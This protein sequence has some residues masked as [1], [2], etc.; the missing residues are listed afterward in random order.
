VA[1]WAK[2]YFNVSICCFFN[3]VGHNLSDASR[4]VLIPQIGLSEDL[5]L[6]DSSKLQKGSQKI[7]RKAF[8]GNTGRPCWSLCPQGTTITYPAVRQIL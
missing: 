4:S 8:T 3:I 6:S 5:N 7:C 2:F 1:I